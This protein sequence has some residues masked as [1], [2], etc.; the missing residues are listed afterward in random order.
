MRLDKL[1]VGTEHDEALF[2]RLGD[3]LL[4][5]GYHPDPSNTWHG[6]A[7]SQEIS[8]FEFT[9]PRGKL[10]VQAETYMGLSISGPT[11]LISEIRAYFPPTR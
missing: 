6:M 5:L 8:H 4:S 3:T 11:E 7:G 2:E 1:V 10:T 9:S